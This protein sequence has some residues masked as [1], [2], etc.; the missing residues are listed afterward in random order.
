MPTEGR[1]GLS[2]ALFGTTT[3]RV[4]HKSPCPVLAVPMF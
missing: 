4:L 2:D 1:H 3:E